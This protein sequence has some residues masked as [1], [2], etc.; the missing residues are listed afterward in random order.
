M[1][2][3]Y[4]FIGLGF[5]LIELVVI[6]ALLKKHKPMYVATLIAITF[7]IVGLIRTYQDR[8]LIFKH[9]EK[10][11]S[12]IE[13]NNNDNKNMLI[14]KKADAYH[15]G[16]NEINS[17]EDVPE[18]FYRHVY[19]LYRRPTDG[20]CVFCS[21]YTIS[22]DRILLDVEDDTFFYFVCTKEIA[23]KILEIHKSNGGPGSGWE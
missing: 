12:Q 13:Q 6:F 17:I 23:D 21:D 2:K 19:Y 20:K 10:N 11:I 3:N 8:N 1:E 16:P 4:F 7:G 5:C 22:P 15:S 14:K 9:S 18:E